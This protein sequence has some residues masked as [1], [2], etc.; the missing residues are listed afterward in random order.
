[1]QK[2]LLIAFGGALGSMARYWVGS[3]V[4][5]RMGIRLPYG[6]LAVNLS[7]C[8]LIGFSLTYLG[9]RTEINPAWRMMIG[10]GFI[11]AYS[12]FSTFEWETFTTLRSGAFWM[13]ALYAG[14]SVLLGLVGIWCGSALAEAI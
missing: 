13:A 12:T 1:L 7:A 14:G 3:A 8:L 4:G 2:Y 11:G 6:T 9:E 10:M 5:S